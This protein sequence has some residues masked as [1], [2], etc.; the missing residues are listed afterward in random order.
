MPLGYE[1]GTRHTV[2]AR[3][4]REQG[5]AAGRCIDGQRG[6]PSM[7]HNGVKQEIGE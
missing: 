4:A 7:R 2:G 6:K 1:A 3:P 5:L